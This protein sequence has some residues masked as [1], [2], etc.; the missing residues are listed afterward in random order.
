[1]VLDAVN[2]FP[3]SRNAK[4]PQGWLAGLLGLLAIAFVVE[5]VITWVVS[6]DKVSDPFW[7]RVFHLGGLLAVLGLFMGVAYLLDQALS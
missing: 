3:V 5:T 4:S 6:R 2:G 1:M 7:L